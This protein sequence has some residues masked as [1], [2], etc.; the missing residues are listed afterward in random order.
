VAGS[1]PDGGVHEDG[2]V[3]AHDVLVEQS[4][5]LPPVLFDIIFEFNAELTVVI[6]CAQSVIDF[7]GGKYKSILLTVGNYFLKNVF[8]CHVL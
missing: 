3:D 7:T 6:D 8:L 2:R 4:H 5:R 1:L